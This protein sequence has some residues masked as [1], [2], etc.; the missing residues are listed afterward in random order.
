MTGKGQ[1]G[2]GVDEAGCQPAESPIPEAGIA[3]GRDDIFEIP[4]E[5]L[6]T[7]PADVVHIDI[8]EIRF[9]QAAHEK[10]NGKIID[11]FDF[12]R[13]IGLVGT[14]PIFTDQIANHVGN[15]LIDFVQG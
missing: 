4:T 11:L 5:V 1:G 2:Q 6:Q 8:E 13:S 10:F 12:F 15:G 7:V 14:D 3:F 9:Q